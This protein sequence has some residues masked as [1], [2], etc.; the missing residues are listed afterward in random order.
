MLEP[1]R[2]AQAFAQFLRALRE[3]K[4]NVFAKGSV[5]GADAVLI[6]P[7][8][9]VAGAGADQQGGQGLASIRAIRLHRS[10]ARLNGKA[11]LLC[12]A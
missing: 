1:L 8:S 11:V 10:S 9:A 4:W 3:K 7:G 12:P 6:L 2:Q 5:V